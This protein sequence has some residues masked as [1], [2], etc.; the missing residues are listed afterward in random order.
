MT[1][2][3]MPESKQR[4]L[5]VAI[6]IDLVAYSGYYLANI[7]FL[8]LSFPV[9]LLLLPFSDLK[10]RL[11]LRVA[12]RYAH[13]LTQVYLPGFGVCRVDEVSGLEHAR[14][15]APF[16]CVAN[17]RGRL[18]ALLLMGVLRRTAVL[19]KAKHAR[20]PMLAHLVRHCGFVSVDQGSAASVALAL[21]K[22]RA[23][24]QSGIH[25]LVFPEGARTT[26]TGLRRFGNMAFRVAID[27]G[28]P[29]V[30]AVVH[31]PRAFMAREWATFFPRKTVRYR[32]SFLPR[33]Y[34]R[35]NDTPSDFSDR[36][37]RLMARELESLDRGMEQGAR[38][39]QR[40]PDG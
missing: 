6:P 20:F 8:L 19:I 31:T 1:G 26:G 5:L 30:P 9:A 35:E 39:A 29:V 40:S 37:Y 24:L 12:H 15:D 18:D 27:C 7:L 36:V 25:L 13:F 16:I 33:V 4:S 23:L 22:C 21:G 38:P 34:P 32:L 14:A 3:A 10:Q 17:H 2:T 11:F 28:M